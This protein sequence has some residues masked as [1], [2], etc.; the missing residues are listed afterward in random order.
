[1]DILDSRDLDER[2]DE[3]ESELDELADDMDEDDRDELTALIGLRES[4]YAEGWKHGI[5][6]IAESDFEEYAQQFADDLGLIDSSANWPMNCI[7]WEYAAK[8]LAHDY[9]MVTFR[10]TDYYYREA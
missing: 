5:A 1:M 8:E 6:F 9:S 3:L 4:T 10:G 2:I 7:D